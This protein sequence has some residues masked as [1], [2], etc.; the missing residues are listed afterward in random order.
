MTKAR[1]RSPSPSPTAR[2]ASAAAPQRTERVGDTRRATAGKWLI[3]LTGLIVVVVAGAVAIL[4][5]QSTP[6]A[7]SAT[8]PAGAATSI[9]TSGALP[10]YVPGPTDTAVGRAIPE[11][12]GTSF[13]GTTVSVTADGRAKVVLFLA[14]WCLH[15]QREV[16][17]VQSW[18]NAGRLPD[19]V[20]V[21]SVATANDPN[22]P[23]YPPEQWLTREGWTPPVLVDETGA[24]SEAY[25]LSA[26]PYWVV[27]RADGT[28]ATRLT[29]ELTPEQ[30][31]ALA[32]SSSVP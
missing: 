20:D 25:G 2:R 18:L 10:P 26:F 1:G 16:P 29:G 14:H 24:F 7:P 13:D 32:A 4:L 11:V 3:P 23:N 15:C 30:L 22:R 17:V 19:G 31:D 27:V 5:T 9:S 6:S 8:Q 28:V 21:F 12:R